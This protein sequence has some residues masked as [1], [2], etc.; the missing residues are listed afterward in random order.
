MT[1]TQEL[2]DTH[3]HIFERGFVGL[4]GV[5]L[6]EPG[7]ELQTYERWCLSAGVVRSLVVG[8]DEESYVG[9]SDY[10]QQLAQSREWLIPL[11]YTP[12]GEQPARFASAY[13]GSERGA[14]VLV[15][16]LR[17]QAR[18]N[19]APRILSLNATPAM[20]DLLGEV[21]RE[22][23]ETWFLI[24][25]LGLPGH[26]A[27]RAAALEELAPILRL[28]GQPNVSVKISGQY[29]A[30]AGAYPH[31][32][33]QPLVDILAEHMGVGALVWGS[34]FSPCLDFVTMAEATQCQLPSGVTAAERHAIYFQNAS[35]MYARF[36]GEGA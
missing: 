24:S 20:I 18:A 32:D 16:I 35:D 31:D 29:A 7:E 8:Y 13:P 21:I 15:G 1:F 12:A 5:R 6:S 25:H 11:R 2:F 34:D 27:D 17:E 9:N 23:D 30:S 28:G 10:V 14:Q 3:C 19:S 26:V 36:G 4:N 33:V 22:L